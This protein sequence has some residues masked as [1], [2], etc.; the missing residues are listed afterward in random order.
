MRECIKSVIFLFADTRWL[1]LYDIISFLISRFVR[2][3]RVVDHSVPDIVK[4]KFISL[5]DSLAV[6]LGRFG[7]AI[8]SKSHVSV[9]YRH[10]P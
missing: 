1:L 10:E 5:M 7:K 9:Y 2:G 3:T 4:S 8:I 6:L